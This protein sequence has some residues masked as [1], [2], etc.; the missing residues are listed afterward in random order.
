MPHRDYQYE[1]CQEDET[2]HRLSDVL[3]HSRSLDS[4]QVNS[5]TKDGKLY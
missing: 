5:M 4:D 3:Y 1:K 2:L